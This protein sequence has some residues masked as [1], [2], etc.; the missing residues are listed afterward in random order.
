MHRIVLSLVFVLLPLNGTYSQT[1]NILDFGAK[2]SESFINTDPIND[3]IRQCSS[4]GGGIVII[5][6]GKFIT[7]TVHL[8]SNVNL[9]LE[10]GS[11][12]IGSKDVNQYDIMPEGYY[13][14][15]KNLMGIIFANDVENIS[16][17]CI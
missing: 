1:F 15:G 8:K 4:V 9:H 12:L 13:Y 11:Y 17:T 7:G 16:I 3:A 2:S 10:T 14:S 6:K 5:P